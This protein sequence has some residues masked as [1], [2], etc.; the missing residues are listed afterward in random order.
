MRSKQPS[1]II[2]FPTTADAMAMEQLAKY[3]ELSGKLIPVPHFMST[4]C[5]MAWLGRPEDRERTL[6]LLVEK[7]VEW[8][9][10]VCQEY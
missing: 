5:G 9:D 7:E 2:S 8:E 10:V 3:H 1:L 6:Q 4:G